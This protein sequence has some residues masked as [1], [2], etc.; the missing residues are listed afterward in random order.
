METSLASAAQTI[1]DRCDQLA[2]FS[3]EPGLIVRRYGTVPM[4][5]VNA[6]V[7]EWMR[8]AG[9]TATTD[10]L[11]NVRGR[12]EAERSG[13]RTLLLG[14]HL[15]T[16]RDAGR[17]DGPLGV[18][19][20]LMFVE[21][22]HAR[23]ARLPFAV[24]V[25]GFADEEGLRYHTAF[26][27]SSGVSG[28]FVPAWLALEDDDGIPLVDAI[29]AFGG[30]PDD[31]PSDRRASDDLLGYVECH[32]EQ[33]P[34]LESRGLP[35]GVVS[36][37]QGQSGYNVTFIGQ[38]GHAGTV[39][40]TLR[41]DALIAASEFVLAVEAYAREQDGVV[42]TVGQLALHPGASN[43]IPGRVTLSL[44]LRHPRDAT[45]H[46]AGAA[47]GERAEAIAARRGVAVRY[48]LLQDSPAVECSPALI[49]L[50]EQAIADAG[51]PVLSLPSGAGHDG[52]RMSALAP[53][54]MLFIRCAGGIS[55][56][57][58]ESVS[59]ADVAVALDV[60]ERFAARLASRVEE[61]ESRA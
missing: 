23:G 18:M 47:L 4:R 6:T 34:V 29:R 48:D 11:G 61:E 22:L 54:A 8:A 32:I 46:A 9:M 12:Y 16:V 35:V 2:R 15:D 37:I 60:L 7:L 19:L 28:A 14:S 26:L 57:P 3:E 27:G 52:M 53:I 36:A 51:H 1:L 45:R 5:E 50:L 43:V 24:E 21:R 10:T 42:A 17:Y 38:A 55:H 33:G 30:N 39:P 44:D 49:D 56:N 41:H 58:A 13:A 31:I 25:L 59:A 20:A 40:M